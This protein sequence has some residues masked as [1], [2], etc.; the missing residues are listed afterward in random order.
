ML[1]VSKIYSVAGLLSEG[2]ITERPFRSPHHTA[3]EVA[4]TGG[5][6]PPVPG[7][8]S[9]AHRGV[10]FLDELPEFS[11]RSLEVLR[12]PIEDGHINIS[13]A[14]GRVN[15]PAKFTL[16][17]AQNPCPCGN[18]GNPFKECTCTRNQR[19]WVN[20]VKEEDLI[21]RVKGESSGEIRGRVLR[22]Y[23]IQR[24]RFRNSETDFNG[25]MTN[26][27]VERFCLG[28]M[29]PEAE[30]LLK[31]A[32]ERF[33]LSGRGYFRTLKVA[34]TVADLEASE[35]IGAEHIAQALQ[36]RTEEHLE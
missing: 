34:R 30:R 11:R 16:I 29:K 1:E 10:L 18:F 23:K 12:Q 14:Q 36:F 26:A 32:V 6:S 22:A 13:R 31:E 3:S 21:R 33:R 7:E 4:L 9:L 35:F 17:T 20:P 24:E 8:I 5:G 27:E 25:R 15:L 19:V 2:L 28:T